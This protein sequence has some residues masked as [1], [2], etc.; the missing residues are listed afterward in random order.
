LQKTVLKADERFATDSLG[1][2]AEVKAG[3]F[4][5]RTPLEKKEEFLRAAWKTA[6]F[7]ERRPVFLKQIH[8]GIV[9]TFLNGSLPTSV[10]TGDAIVTDSKEVFL[11]IQVADCLPVLIY[12]PVKKIIA[13]AHSGWKGSLLGLAKRTVEKMAE[14]GS[15]PRDLLAWLGPSIQSCCYEVDVERAVL[16]TRRQDQPRFIDLALFNRRLLVGAGL[17]GRNII[18]DWRCT[19]CGAENLPSYRREGKRAGRIFAYAALG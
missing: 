2:S 4:V 14:L 5:S 17:E 9:H 15:K 18:T 11:V 8:S 7:P 13:G 12:D 6:G 16:F 1:K 19:V 3:F 10:P